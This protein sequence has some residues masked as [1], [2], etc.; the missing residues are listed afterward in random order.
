MPVA[1]EYC[2]RHPLPPHPHIAVSCGFTFKCPISPAA[3]L[4]PVTIFPFW[5]TPPPTPV[6]SVTITMLLNPLPP[7]R[8]CSPSAATLASLPALT[9]ATPV[10]LLNSL[11]TEKIPHPRFTHLS[12]LPSSVTG[13]GTPI[14]IPVISSTEILSSLFFSLIEA[15]ISGSIYEPLSSFL[16][17]ISHLVIIL[18]SL[19]KSPILTVVPPKSIP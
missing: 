2:S 13:P 18:P 10:S 7:P 9:F 8:H 17:A 15:A 6:P 1:E 19:S 16:V 14:P 5:I 11:A 12:T 4:H 3:P